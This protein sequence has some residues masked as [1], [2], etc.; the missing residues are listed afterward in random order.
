MMNTRYE[1]LKSMA[2]KGRRYTG[3][4]GGNS[5]KADDSRKENQCFEEQ[6]IVMEYF[7]DRANTVPTTKNNVPELPTVLAVPRVNTVVVHC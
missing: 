2:R 5:V 7:R 6:I 4:E 1:C 3:S